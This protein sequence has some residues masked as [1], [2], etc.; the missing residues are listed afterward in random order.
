LI[1]SVYPFLFIVLF[2]AV[3]TSKVLAQDSGNEH[4]IEIPVQTHDFDTIPEGPAYKDSFLIIN[5]GSS[6]LLINRVKTACKCLTPDWPQGAINPQ[7]TAKIRYTF[8]SDN[9]PGAFFKAMQVYINIERAPLKIF[10]VGGYVKPD[11]EP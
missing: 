2:L 5:K 9:R 10:Y 3:N 1:N 8:F 11:E 6:P 4:E 7:D